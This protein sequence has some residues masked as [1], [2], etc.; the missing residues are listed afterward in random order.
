MPQTVTTPP[1]ET[2]GRDFP[3]M[4]Q[5]LRHSILN[6]ETPPGA[7]LREQALAERFGVSR[8]RLREALAA[9]EQAGLVERVANRGAVVRRSSATE[10]L[11]VFE[12]REAL[13]G[14]S[15]RLATQQAAPGHWAELVLLF[16][17]RT[18]ALVAAGD[19]AGYLRHLDLLRRRTLEA[20]AN[21]VLAASLQ[22][23]L[24]RTSPVMRRLLLATDRLQRALDEHR[25]VL[26]AM[27]AGDADAAERLKRAQ[28]R[29]ARADFERYSS[30]IL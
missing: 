7:P 3:A 13:E 25:A 27:A 19:V 22:P 29:S 28:V 9:L 8:A 10:L 4:V 6:G 23:L 15:A 12:V 20:A 24:D 30:F 11:Q 1:P 18:G 21:P 5:A 2:A 17:A 14:L 26:A 16:G